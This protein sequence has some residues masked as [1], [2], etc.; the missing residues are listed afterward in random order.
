MALQPRN[1]A[2]V[3]ACLAGTYATLLLSRP[4]IK[5]LAKEGGWFESA[6]ALALLVAGVLFFAAFLRSRKPVNRD[7]FPLVKRMFLLGMAVLFV[8]G[9][10]EEISWGQRVFG[11]ETPAGLAAVNVQGETNLHN[12]AWVPDEDFALF[13]ICWGLV[14]I[15]LPL[16]AAVSGPVRRRADRLVPIVP[17]VL[18]SLFVVNYVMSKAAGMVVPYLNSHLSL[19][20][21]TDG[22]VEIQESNFSI[23]AALIALH[24]YRFMLQPGAVKQAAAPAPRLVSVV[25]DPEAQREDRAFAYA[26]DWAM[27][28]G[29]ADPRAV[30]SGKRRT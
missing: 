2:V 4:V 9:A 16:V 5:A 10:G 13:M 19:S 7:A 3:V 8:F 12:L 26:D 28:T 25:P 1:L 15:A 24:I 18:G 22:R 21:L 20:R 11:V 23:L 29:S 6:G 30:A 27:M 17:L 14:V